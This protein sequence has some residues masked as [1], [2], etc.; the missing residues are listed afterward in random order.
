[1]LNRTL[2]AIGLA[3]L[4]IFLIESCTVEKRKYTGGFHVDWNE[5]HKSRTVAKEPEKK[6][7]PSFSANAHEQE[8]DAS[9]EDLPKK[10]TIAFQQ[11][12]KGKTSDLVATREEVDPIISKTKHLEDQ[13]ELQKYQVTTEDDNNADY[14]AKK[15]KKRK[16]LGSIS[17][18]LGVGCYLVEILAVILAA[19]GSIEIGLFLFL[20]ISS[21]LMAVIAFI[22]G[23]I[24]IKKAR[25]GKGRTGAIIGIVL[26]G[27]FLLLTLIGLIIALAGG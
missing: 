5:H 21:F 25:K 15:K 20:L 26:G 23:L 24:A 6:L 3:C 27:I 2:T 13:F 10:D 12:I 11:K 9:N 19:K 16:N 8:D 4:F 22:L 18:F 14:G 1:M 17:G 7:V